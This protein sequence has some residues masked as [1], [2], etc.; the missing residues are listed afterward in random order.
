MRGPS[1]EAAGHLRQLT[2]I[3]LAI[4]TGVV[5][6]AG[7]VWYLLN[8][9]AFIPPESVPPYLATVLNLVGLL[10]LLKAHLLP[11]F[12]RPPPQGAAEEDLLGWHRQVTIIAFALREAAA[13][14]ALVGALLTG[15]LAAATA[16]VGLV[17]VTMILAWPRADQIPRS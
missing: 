3:C 1:A 9:G 6:F 5:L 11:R 14:G 2:I 8:S 10:F 13:L 16:I 4:L 7:V 17:V 15:K 12:F